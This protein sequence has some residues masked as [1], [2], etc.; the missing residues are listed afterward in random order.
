MSRPLMV[1]VYGNDG[2]GKSTL[3]RAIKAQLATEGV[4]CEVFDK[5]D[6]L[7]ADLS[8]QTQFIKPDIDALR[9]AISRM[10]GVSRT[11]FLFWSIAVTLRESSADVVLLDGYWFKHGAAE[12]ALGADRRLVEA[13]GSA[14]PMPD[15]AIHLDVDPMVAA[16]RKQLRFTPY[17]CGCVEPCSLDLFIGHQG[18]VRAALRSIKVGRSAVLI[19]A[20][21][22]AAE[23]LSRAMDRIRSTVGQTMTID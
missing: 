5:W 2:A 13:L 16:E 17:E 10:E 6:I 1:A 7:S 11:L 4:S 19:D 3:V 23:V 20:G 14:L 15:V 21:L 9:V 8:P 22:P 12:I 18:R